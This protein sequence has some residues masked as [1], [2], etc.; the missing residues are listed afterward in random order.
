MPGLVPHLVGARLPQQAAQQLRP[1]DLE[2]QGR[3]VD[4]VCLSVLS[5]ACH[6][7]VRGFPARRPSMHACLRAELRTAFWAAAS[8]AGSVST[9]LQLMASAR[10]S[11]NSAA[12]CGVA[13]AARCELIGTCAHGV[14]ACTCQGSFPSW[15]RHAC[16]RPP[17][18]H[19]NF[20]RH[21][22]WGG[23]GGCRPAHAGPSRATYHIRPLE[24]FP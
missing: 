11:R 20:G 13:A 24:L 8:A 6:A 16:T 7:R 22:C 3:R 18:V 4:D 2:V 17:C 1:C 12:R 19:G 10:A 23:G 21:A 9:A 14:H 5:N 15:R